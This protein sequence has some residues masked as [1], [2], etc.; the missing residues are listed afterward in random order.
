MVIDY[1]GTFPVIPFFERRMYMRK[2]LSILIALSLVVSLFSGFVA[3]PKSVSAATLAPT[4]VKILT[5]TAG[6]TFSPDDE[7][8]LNAVVSNPDGLNGIVGATATLA[9]AGNAALADGETATKPIDLP[10]SGVADVWWKVV[11]TDPGDVTLTVTSGAGHADVLV[12]QSG[13]VSQTGDVTVTWVESPCGSPFNGIVPVGTFFAVKARATLSPDFEGVYAGASSMTIHYSGNLQLIGAATVPVGD[14]YATRPEEAG[15]NFKCLGTGPASVWVEFTSADVLPANVSYVEMPC[16]FTQ[17]TPP[18]V[19]IPGDITLTAPKKVCTNCAQ[20]TFTVTAQWNNGTTTASLVYATLVID[21]PLLAAFQTTTIVNKPGESVAAGTNS[22]L[23][24]WN[25]ICL[26]AGPTSLTVQLRHTATGPVFATKSI[27]VQQTDYMV[28]LGDANQMVWDPVTMVYGTNPA[29]QVYADPAIPTDFVYWHPDTLKAETEVCDTF[30][31]KTTFENCTCAPFGTPGVSHVIAQVNLP[32]TVDLYGMV[33]IQEWVRVSDAFGNAYGASELKNSYQIP[34]QAVIDNGYILPLNTQCACCYFVITWRLKCIGADAAY[35]EVRFD[36][37][38]NTDMTTLL[39]SASFMLLQSGGA[40]IQTGID[41]FQGWSSDSTLVTTPI[42]VIAAPCTVGAGTTAANHFTVVIPVVNTGAA[43]NNF[44][45]SGTLTGDYAYVG[46]HTYPTALG[47]FSLIGTAWTWTIPTLPANSAF[48]LVLELT[49]TGPIDVVTTFTSATGTDAVTGVPIIGTYITSDD[50]DTMDACGNY[51]VYLRG[52]RTLV[53]IPLS[54]TIVEPT[55]GTTYPV[56][57]NYAVKIRVQNCSTVP[58]EIFH[59]L[60]ATLNWGTNDL[61]EFNQNV[62]PAETATHQLG[63]LAPGMYAETLWQVHCTGAGAPDNFSWPPTLADIGTTDTDGQS[64][65]SPVDG[66]PVTF[67]VT[68]NAVDPNYEATQS[69]TVYQLPDSNVSVRVMSPVVN[70][71]QEIEYATGEKFAVTA[72]VK[73]NGLLPATGIVINV[74]S[75]VDPD[76]LPAYVVVNDPNTSPSPTLPFDLQPGEGKYITWTIEAVRATQVVE[77]MW[78]EAPIGHSLGSAIGLAYT[79]ANSNWGISRLTLYNYPAAHLVVHL[80]PIP[81][82]TAG[83][84]FTITG[85]VTNIGGADATSVYLDLSTLY[86]DV[87]PAVGSSNRKYIG[88]LPGNHTGMDP[89]VVPFTWNLESE[90]SGKTSIRVTAEGQDEYGFSDLFAVGWAKDYTTWQILDSWTSNFV[91]AYWRTWDEFAMPLAPIPAFCIE[92]ADLTFKQV[93]IVPPV[94]ITAPVI[95]PTAGQDGAI[96][97]DPHFTLTGTVTDNVGVASF[98]IGTTKVDV[99]PDGTF[100]YPVV[101]AV[102]ANMFTYRAFDAA[103]NMATTSIT[104]TYVILVDTTAPVITPTA[105]QDGAIV[106]DPHFTLTGTVT[107]NVGVTSFY[108][109]TTK[110][111]FLPDGTFAYPVMLAEG[112]NTFTYKAFDAAGNMGTTSITVT[113]VVPVNPLLKMVQLSYIEG[114]NLVTV[115]LDST[116]LSGLAGDVNFTGE[117]YGYSQTAGWFIPTGFKAG[118]GYWLNMKAAG[119]VNIYGYEVASPQ[120][121]TYASGWVLIGSPYSVGG[122]TVKVIVGVNPPML[123]K[124]AV[125]MNYVG[126]IFYFDGGGWGVFDATIDTIQPGLGYWVELKVGASIVFMKP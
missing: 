65:G 48:K 27:T 113:Y 1:F 23:W 14:L 107:D 13:T 42:S 74:W 63:D 50:V 3:A 66:T 58:T 4:G 112:A 64:L 46:Y 123:L 26:A 77:Y 87:A 121:T 22:S 12:H 95:T 17:G 91:D 72:Y 40:H 71:G 124:D 106:N 41:Y 60:T 109:G 81:D 126:T 78:G 62:V 49:C 73:N 92:S 57:S 84:D 101:L 34:A 16:E 83:T 5:P 28:L 54:W 111:D 32:A 33:T 75:S 89:L 119:M 68:L 90:G 88:T 56:S 21:N 108:V 100:G 96:V 38:L 76:L 98:W 115:P 99:L 69:V 61:V 37:H 59:D 67:D 114:W 53:Q 104:V 44:V 116:T 70:P 15:W 10:A 51:Q 18:P 43:V 94:D 25:I 36:A 6:A 102:G 105:G 97:N 93:A 47:T 79:S 20:N 2:F 9:I 35:Q 7:F 85:T 117:I 39:D 52:P 122:D 45:L 82:V 8:Y 19:I 120:V 55:G 31:V 86:G 118:Q 103:G 110:I 80:D 24:T 29:T 125:A 11:C 30:T